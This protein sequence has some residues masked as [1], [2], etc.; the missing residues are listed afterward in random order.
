MFCSKCGASI[1]D[2]ARVCSLCGTTLV[3]E[4][5]PQAVFVPISQPLPGQINNG[6]N[7]VMP[8]DSAIDPNWPVKSKVAAGLLG[9]FLGGFGA[10]KF[11]LGKVGMGILYLLFSWTMIP[12]FVGIVEGIICLCSDDISFQIKNHVRINY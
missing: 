7:M 2:D 12:T 1:E 5:S 9:F 6:Q 10:H 3:V 8:Q 11:Y 4:N